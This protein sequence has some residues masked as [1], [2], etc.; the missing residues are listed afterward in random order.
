ML[1]TLVGKG[2]QSLL[3]LR[4]IQDQTLY[5]RGF[6]SGVIWLVRDGRL[7]II[8]NN[9]VNVRGWKFCFPKILPPG[10]KYL[11]CKFMYHHN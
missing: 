10:H 9:N 1:G 2:V 3:M 8:Y 11:Y 6:K 7:D 5:F 4:R